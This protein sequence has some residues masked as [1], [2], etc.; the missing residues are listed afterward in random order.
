MITLLVIV[1]VFCV[2]KE[3]IATT[4][5]KILMRENIDKIDKFLVIRQNFLDQIF[6]L[7]VTNVATASRSH[8]CFIH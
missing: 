2:Y 7:A 8:Q 5:H 4:W 6:L 1:Q 3:E